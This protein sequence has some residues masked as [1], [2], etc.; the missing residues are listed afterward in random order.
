MPFLITG[1]G[2]SGTKYIS[3]VLRVCGLGVGHERLGIDGC[4]SG[5]YC[6]ETDHYPGAHVSPRPK[7]D[8][9]LHQVREPLKSIASVTTG[10]SRKWAQQ[11]VNVEKDASPLRW[12]CHYWLTWN[13]EAERQALFTYR[14]EAL[15]DVWPKLQ[16][17][18]SFNAP[19]SLVSEIPKTIN[20]RPHR[21]CNWNQIKEAAP[22]I[23][24]EI[25]DAAWRYG[26]LG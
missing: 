3:A 16:E 9:I 24:D 8:V 5:F 11:F 19:Y 12:A 20:K 13:K 1:S 10:R 18:L 14:V 7:F 6:F 15:K 25:K 26:Y 22:E 17:A 4:V 23:Y 2:R 21:P